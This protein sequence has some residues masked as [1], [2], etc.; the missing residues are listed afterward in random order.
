MASPSPSRDQN[1]TDPSRSWLVG[2]DAP[3]AQPPPTPSAPESNSSG[4][5]TLPPP[6]T[7]TKSH[8]SGPGASIADAVKTIKPADLLTVHHRPC[9]RDGFLTGIGGGAAVGMV[10]WVMGMPVPRAANWAVGAGVAAATLQF[11]YCQYRR[12]Q[13]REKMKRVVEVYDRRQTEVR[14]A[15]E[16]AAKQRQLQEDKTVADAA[17]KSGAKSWYRFW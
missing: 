6:A 13:E 7:P 16:A 4:A 2:Q 14:A 1:P 10:R 11:E 17:P 15:E 3:H 8:S 9:A 12:R 5:G